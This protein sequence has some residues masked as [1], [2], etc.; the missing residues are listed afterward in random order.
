MEQSPPFSF[1]FAGDLAVDFSDPYMNPM[2]STKQTKVEEP[3]TPIS[4]NMSSTSSDSLLSVADKRVKEEDDDEAASRKRK[5]SVVH[6]GNDKRQVLLQKNRVAAQKCREKKKR[7][8]EGMMQR[9]ELLETQNEKLKRETKLLTEETN[10]LKMMIMGHVSSTPSCGYFNEWIE[11]QAQAV[12]KKRIHTVESPDCRPSAQIVR[13]E[14]MASTVSMSSSGLLSHQELSFNFDDEMNSQTASWPLQP[15][16][17]MDASFNTAM[18]PYS[19]MSFGNLQA[20]DPI[21][22]SLTMAFSPVVKDEMESSTHSSPGGRTPEA[23]STSPQP[24][25]G[26]ITRATSFERDSVVTSHAK[27]A[28]GRR[29]SSIPNSGEVFHVPEIR[30]RTA[31]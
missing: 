7:E 16:V 2:E 9:C 20:C 18:A 29:R 8:T 17:S 13:K 1:D 21:D 5:T 23:L 22:P 31:Q 30:G 26:S 10:N 12:I 24:T 4:N 14:S 27:K 3:L 15:Q 6:D 28:S 19:T 25:V 11:D